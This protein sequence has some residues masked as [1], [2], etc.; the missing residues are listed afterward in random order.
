[1]GFRIMNMIRFR[2][3]VWHSST[4]KPKLGYCI[5]HGTLTEIHTSSHNAS[6]KFISTVYDTLTSFQY[7]HTLVEGNHLV[8]GH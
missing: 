7:Y 6:V 4:K 8:C 3:M 5:P 2:Q 1:M